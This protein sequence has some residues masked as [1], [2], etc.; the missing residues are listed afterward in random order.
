MQFGIL[1]RIL[2]CQWWVV[3]CTV[4]KLLVSCKGCGI[5]YLAK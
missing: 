1:A 3:L 2:G 4:L 5:S